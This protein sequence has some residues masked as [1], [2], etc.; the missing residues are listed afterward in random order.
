MSTIEL[1]HQRHGYLN[2]NELM[3]L[4][5]NTMVEGLHEMKNDHI[6]C[7]TCV[8]GKKHREEFLVHKEKIQREIF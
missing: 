4:Q 1:W 2:H 6:E 7:E 5:Q 8:L 3:L